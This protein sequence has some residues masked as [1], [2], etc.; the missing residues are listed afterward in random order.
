MSK[1]QPAG[2][3][4]A[5]SGTAIAEFSKTEAALADLRHRYKG[6]VAPLAYA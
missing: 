1:D 2:A 3:A 4:P 6:V 5:A